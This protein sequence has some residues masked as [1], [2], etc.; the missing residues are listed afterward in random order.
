MI[1]ALYFFDND[2][3]SIN[4]FKMKYFHNSYIYYSFLKS[5]Y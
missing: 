1:Y 2:I 5:K 3:K 4:L